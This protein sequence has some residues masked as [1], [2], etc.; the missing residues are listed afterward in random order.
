MSPNAERI[1]N[2]T[3]EMDGWPIS[4]RN[5][6][7]IGAL[8]AETAAI[9]ETTAWAAPRSAGND[10]FHL[11]VSVTDSEDTNPDP[12]IVILG[13]DVPIRDLFEFGTE[14]VATLHLR[15]RSAHRGARMRWPDTTDTRSGTGRPRPAR[16]GRVHVTGTD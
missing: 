9:L 6:L 15:A 1:Q 13:R 16:P 8:A 14:T 4:R 11:P 5:I 3:R 7:K 2:G 12:P 10:R